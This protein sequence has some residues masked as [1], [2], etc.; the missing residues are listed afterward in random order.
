MPSVIQVRDYPSF[1]QVVVLDDISLHI[2][3]RYNSRDSAWMM[4]IYDGDDSPIVQ[5]IKLVPNWELIG[6]FKDTRLPGGL[7]FAVDISGEGADIQRNDLIEK[8]K[9]VYFSK[10]E[11]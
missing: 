11:I 10:D 2:E 3:I 8:V 6:R 5:G 7:L 9:L 1:E 4:D